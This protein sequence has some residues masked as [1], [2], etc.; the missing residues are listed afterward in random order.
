M[1]ACTIPI[2]LLLA[3]LDAPGEQRVISLS[4]TESKDKGGL[5]FLVD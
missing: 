5:F 3:I 4:S 2:D 1:L